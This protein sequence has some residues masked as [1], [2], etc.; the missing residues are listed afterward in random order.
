MYPTDS[1]HHDHDTAATPDLPDT[2]RWILPHRMALRHDHEDTT[3]SGSLVAYKTHNRPNDTDF[4][5]VL[6]AA[7]PDLVPVAHLLMALDDE[8]ETVPDWTSSEGA[9]PLPVMAD[10]MDA[11]ET[12]G[13][14]F[15]WI[16]STWRRSFAAVD[17]VS[18]LSM[19]LMQPRSLVEAADEPWRAFEEATMPP[20]MVVLKQ[21]HELNV[22]KA[23]LKLSAYFEL[24][25]FMRSPERSSSV[26]R[27]T[28][29]SRRSLC[30]LYA[31]KDPASTSS[32]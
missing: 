3:L 12:P 23:T 17:L 22:A 9:P 1:T 13:M 7:S 24:L 2:A 28:L 14:P 16:E 18:T 27:K 20:A 29:L 8:R 30:S 25:G 26:S 21:V 19:C 6:G 31:T 4:V 15:T 5:Q 32:D 11:S 10:K